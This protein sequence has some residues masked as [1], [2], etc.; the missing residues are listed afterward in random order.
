VVVLGDA[1][2][3][4]RKELLLRRAGRQCFAISS[5][6][7]FNEAVGR[8]RMAQE[9][10]FAIERWSSARRLQRWPTIDSQAHAR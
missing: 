2:D 3:G 8:W 4:G 10:R 5:S 6:V 1:V 7:G 9:A